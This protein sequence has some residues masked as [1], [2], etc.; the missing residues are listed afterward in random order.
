MEIEIEIVGKGK[1]IGKLDDRNP[2]TAK[3]IYEI[4]PVPG[5][6]NVYLEEMYF[7]IPAELDYENP[8]GST[9]KGDISYWPPGQAFC[10]F[11][12]DSQPYSEVNNFGKI[13]ENLEVLKT[14]EDGDEIIIRKK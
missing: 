9:E 3:K 1:A 4:L 8:S 11:Y 5:D 14:C 12:G 7:R 13:T 10:I 6:A 2:E